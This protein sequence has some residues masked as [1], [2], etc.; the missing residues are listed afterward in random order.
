MTTLLGG[1]GLVAACF[2]SKT[3]NELFDEEA[4][5]ALVDH[6]LFLPLLFLSLA[7][8]SLPLLLPCLQLVGISTEAARLFVA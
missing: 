8:R 5:A 6:I 2:L 3:P 4:L 1:S 7:F